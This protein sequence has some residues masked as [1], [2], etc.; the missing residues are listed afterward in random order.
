MSEFNLGNIDNALT[1]ISFFS[2]YIVIT[3]FTFLSLYFG[4]LQG[5]IYLSFTLF[6]IFVRTMIYWMYFQNGTTKIKEEQEKK[7]RKHLLF[8]RILW[9][10]SS[11][12]SECLGIFSY[13]GIYFVSYSFI[14]FNC[15]KE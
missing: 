11:C 12:I 13:F 7:K 4:S 3:F 1:A 10:A 9:F 6:S 14:D 15:F 5:L 8:I 2:P